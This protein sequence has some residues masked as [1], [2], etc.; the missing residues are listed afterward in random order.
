M[1]QKIEIPMTENDLSD[2]LAGEVEGYDWTFP[3]QNGVW[4]DVVI[5]RED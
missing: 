1:K 4:I 5:T 2:L 3:D